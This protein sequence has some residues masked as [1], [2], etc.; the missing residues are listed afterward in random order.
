MRAEL[1]RATESPY[2][3]LDPAR[4]DLP[5]ENEPHLEAWSEY[6][7]EAEQGGRS[8][9]AA[10]LRARLVQLS[11]PIRKGMGSDPA[12]RAAVLA[13]AAPPLGRGIRFSDPEGLRI[14]LHP[15]LAGTV[16]I[17]VC[18]TRADFEALVRALTA[19]NEPIPVPPSMGACLVQGVVNQDRVRRYRRAWAAER[20]SDDPAAWK[21]AFRELAADKASYQDRVLLLSSGP[22]SAVDPRELGLSAEEW[23]EESLA[24][25]RE[26]EC[27]H[28]LTLRLAG[29]IRSDLLDEIAADLAG[30]LAARGAY[31]PALALRFLGL[32]LLPELR[33][34]ARALLYPGKLDEPAL[35]EL[36]RLAG[37]A[38]IRL[39][40]ALDERPALVAA[41]NRTRLP[42]AVAVLGL[43]ALLAPELAARLCELLGN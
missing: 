31:D 43:P 26:H 25:R 34:G 27:F 13:G 28:Y 35:A 12:Y 3:D 5:L 30:L 4:L 24:I 21:Q 19:R 11:F 33:P 36:R 39:G 23:L 14:E 17:V 41:E 1:V 37:A 10:T 9:A 20:G 38:V 7:E 22:Y 8:G 40:E 15:T 6:R 2:R 29:M 42:L 32:D 18:R 16:P